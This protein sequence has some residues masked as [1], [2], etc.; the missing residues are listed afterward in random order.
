MPRSQCPST[1]QNVSDARATQKPGSFLSVRSVLASRARRLFSRQVCAVLRCRH[2]CAV[3]VLEQRS[4]GLNS[5]FGLYKLFRKARH[6]RVQFGNRA[7]HIRRFV[8]VVGIRAASRNRSRL[9]PLL[10]CRYHPCN[11][12]L[13]PAS[14]FRPRSHGRILLQ[15]VS[16]WDAPELRAFRQHPTP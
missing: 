5:V 1:G 9:R 2:H 8:P 6:D 14:Q 16:W 3:Q 4:A 7:K 15:P 10:A 12:A 13:N 11:S